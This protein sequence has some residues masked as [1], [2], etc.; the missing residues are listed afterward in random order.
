[1]SRSKFPVL[2]S[3][4]HSGTWDK[5]VP[6]EWV[7]QFSARAKE[8][9]G[10]QDLYR[11]A[12]RGGLTWRELYV[13]SSGYQ[14]RHST[15]LAIDAHRAVM[16]DILSWQAGVE[17][18]AQQE[19]VSHQKWQEQQGTVGALRQQSALMD[20]DTRI[21]VTT[22]NRSLQPFL[23]QLRVVGVYPDT[24]DRDG[25][26]KSTFKIEVDVVEDKKS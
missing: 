22:K 1:M 15:V 5:F 25:S 16:G 12:E 11:L 13:I 18:K 23:Q 24:T 10:G 9:H 8:L 6:W 20:S 7:E 21:Q 17:Q 4:D 2:H 3:T 14:Q 19:R 26:W